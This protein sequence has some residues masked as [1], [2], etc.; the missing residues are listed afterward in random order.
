MK[1]AIV[2]LLKYGWP[3]HIIANYLLVKPAVVK[4]Y[5][6]KLKITRNEYQ[7]FY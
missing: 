7:G 4:Y 2:K 3:D 5:R 1:E 6:K